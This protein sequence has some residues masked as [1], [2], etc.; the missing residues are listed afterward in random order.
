[1]RAEGITVSATGTCAPGNM[2]WPT[3]YLDAFGHETEGHWFVSEEAVD[4]AV[5]FCAETGLQLN[6]CAMG[7]SEH[8]LFLSAVERLGAR[9]GVVQHGAIMPLAH[10][11][12]WAAAGFRQT[13]CCG[14]TWG[15]GDV[16]RRAFGESVLADLNPLRRLL[17]AGITLAA[18]SDWGP[19]SPWEQIWLAETHL[20]GRS[21]L[22]NDGP[23]Q[24]VTRAEAFAM[25]TAGGAAVLDWPQLGALTLG[26]YADLVVLDRDPL[27]CALDDLPDVVVQATMTDGNVVFG[28]L[29]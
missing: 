16:Y 23:D 9:R 27:T 21:G 15:K 24:V 8:E 25:W 26:A 22:R 19:K 28:S 13:V 10:A 3:P 18:A 4:Q 7:P 17:D 14:F 29:D 2:R 1:M 11:R 5:G 6:F 12:R 20:L